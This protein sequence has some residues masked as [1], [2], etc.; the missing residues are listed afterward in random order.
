MIW[1]LIGASTI[2]SQHVIDEIRSQDGHDIKG[3]QSC[4]VTH[5]K[6]FAKAHNIA[7][8]IM[9]QRP[10]GNIYLTDESGTREVTFI[11]HNLYQQSLAQFAK[12]LTGHTVKVD[13][14]NI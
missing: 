6:T 10:V 2:A 5:G 11:Q 9:T 4:S 8:E 13:Y 7:H 3:L 12:A 14:G 1:G